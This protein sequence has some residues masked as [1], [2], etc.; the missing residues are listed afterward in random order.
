MCR[1]RAVIFTVGT[2]KHGFFTGGI[3]GV[4]FISFLCACELFVDRLSTYSG[5]FRVSRTVLCP[6]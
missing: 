6:L 2:E 4:S 3:I 5:S 1:L